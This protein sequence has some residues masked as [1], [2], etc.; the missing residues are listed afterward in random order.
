[1]RGGLKR[2]F[3]VAP[4]AW[5]RRVI[6]PLFKKGEKSMCDNYRGIALLSHS[7]KVYTRILEKRLKACVESLLNDSQYGFR[8]GRGTTD[9]IFVAKCS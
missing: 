6:S 3:T 8:P 7:G 5:Q 4:S 9:A 1:M 2:E